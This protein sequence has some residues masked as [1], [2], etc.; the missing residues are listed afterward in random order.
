MEKPA[1]QF[2]AK[3]VGRSYVEGELFWTLLPF[4][5]FIEVDF[6]DPSAVDGGEEGDGI[7]FHPKKSTLPLGLFY[8]RGDNEETEVIPS[9]FCAY[10]PN[11]IQEPFTTPVFKRG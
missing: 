2:L 5:R 9:I 7:I 4:G 6:V 11:L 3:Y 8:K 1:L 10:D